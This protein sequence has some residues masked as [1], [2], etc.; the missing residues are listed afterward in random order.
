MKRSCKKI[1]VRTLQAEL[2]ILAPVTEGVFNGF[3][4]ICTP[5]LQVASC[6]SVPA[7]FWQKIQKNKQNLEK[8]KPVTATLASFSTLSP[9][10]KCWKTFCLAIGWVLA[11]LSPLKYSRKSLFMGCCRFLVVITYFCNSSLYPPFLS[12]LLARFLDSR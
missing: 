1:S 4:K 6:Q 5:G 3:L 9:V 10:E 12:F 11:E 7:R 8:V 2:V